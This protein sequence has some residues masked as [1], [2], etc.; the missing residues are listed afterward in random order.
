MINPSDFLNIAEELIKDNN[1]Q[2]AKH[3]TSISRSYYAAYHEVVIQYAKYKKLDIKDSIFSNHQTFIRNLTQNKSQSLIRTLGNQ[4]H[5]L[6][7]DRFKADYELNKDISLSSA[8]KSY[9]ASKKI[10]NNCRELLKEIP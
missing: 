10:I 2:E 3:R 1:G 4:L 5:S 9:F 8:K 6:K 7:K